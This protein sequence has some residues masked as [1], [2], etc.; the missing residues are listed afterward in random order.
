MKPFIGVVC[1]ALAAV[2]FAEEISSSELSP[3]FDYHR[4][5]GIPRAAELKKLEEEEI[6]TG[7][8][9]RIVGGNVVDISAVPY[10]AG[11]VITLNFFWTSVCGASLISQ[12]RLI[13]A[14]H[15]Q[16]DGNNV[17]NGMTVVLGHNFIFVGGLR[18]FTRDIHMH[19]AW[20]PNNAAN[21][22]AVIRLT[23]SVAFS[24]VIQPIALPNGLESNTFVDWTALA[25]GWGRTVNGGE[26]PEFQRISAVNLPIITNEACTVAYGPW[27]HNSNI[28]T[29]GAG[30]RGTCGG[31][32]GG[33]LAVLIDNTRVLIG[34]TSY[35]SAR[36]CQAGDPAAF[37]RVTSF[38]VWIRSFL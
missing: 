22:I 18:I 14:A 8:S 36:G 24:N 26:I 19:P 11:L 33:P 29:S 17:A 15:C 31:D 30:G 12:N 32:S 3:V 28:C 6:R 4:R 38:L 21:D 16:N 2:A 7:S 9:Q 34:V 5:F 1:L 25:S 23:S 37:A 13:T 10:Q 35:G 27:V 20:N